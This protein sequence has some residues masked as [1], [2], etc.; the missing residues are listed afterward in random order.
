MSLRAAVESVAAAFDADRA[1]ETVRT[2]AALDRYQA[3]EGVERAAD[4]VAAEAE[5]L[6]LAD[7]RL[8]RYSGETTWWTYEA[9]APWTPISAHLEIDGRRLVEYPAT[10]FGLATYSAASPERTLPLAL[11][12][13]ESDVAGR[14]CVVPLEVPLP[15]ALERL[16]AGGAAA[17]VACAAP[18]LDGATGRIELRAGTR[19]VGF[20]VTREALAR[21]VA[22]AREGGRVTFHAEVAQ[23]GSMPLVTARL[24]GGS[25]REIA[26]VAH[27]CHPRPSAND[28]ASGVAATLG[29]ASALRSLARRTPLDHTLRFVWGPELVGSAAYLHDVVATGQAPPPRYLLNLDMVGEDQAACGGPL[30]LEHSHLPSALGAVAE[31]SAALVEPASAW[32]WRATPF[33]GAS[34]HLLFADRPFGVRT[35][36]LG[37]RP[38]RFNHTSSDSVD[39]VDPQELRRS[40][41][42]AGGSV[43]YLATGPP[44]R[45]LTRLIGTWTARTVAQLAEQIA[46]HEPAE[47]ETVDPFAPK[48]AAGLLRHACAGR[49]GRLADSYVRR[50]GLPDE[51]LVEAGPPLRR[52]W[53]G[54]FNLRALEDAAG[55]R[56]RVE[57]DD[58]A[59]V[60]ALALA[61]DGERGAGEVVREAAYASRLPIPLELATRFLETLAR[62]GWVDSPVRA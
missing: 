34:D 51:R 13:D 28:N 56:F 17:F 41:A 4:A 50:L 7:V 42:I 24:P 25:P 36:Q 16:E 21:A 9:P 53:P 32:R 20:S 14:V 5:R 44:A 11:L 60:V 18:G 33:V 26:F 31:R 38:D 40:A 52:A 23:R 12:G 59:R 30:V 35:L 58:Y 19:L 55:G 8:D 57:R 43:L 3:S 46:E 49:L 45:E 2:L 6:G 54:P 29:L 47:P 48:Y 37:H 39:K 22:A 10:A 27:L 61:I 1:L 15:L 62:A